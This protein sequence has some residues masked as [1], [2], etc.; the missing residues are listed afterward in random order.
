MFTASEMIVRVRFRESKFCS[1]AFASFACRRVIESPTRS[2]RFFLSRSRSIRDPVIQKRVI[3][4]STFRYLRRR[5]VQIRFYPFEFSSQDRSR[6]ET[7]EASFVRAVVI[8]ARECAR[9]RADLRRWCVSCADEVCRCIFTCCAYTNDARPVAM[10]AN[11]REGNERPKNVRAFFRA[12]TPDS[13]T[14]Y[15]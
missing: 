8:T 7:P 12:S 5:R 1:R 10:G 6:T 2:P 3:T 13:R 11:A 15:D 9:T 14:V 4:S